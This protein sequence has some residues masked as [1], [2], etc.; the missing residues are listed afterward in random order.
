MLLNQFFDLEFTRPLT[1][2]EC[3]SKIPRYYQSNA[4]NKVADFVEEGYRRILINS[5]TGTGKTFIS[6]LVVLS[7]RVRQ[8]INLDSKSKIR[9]LYIANKHRLNRQA[10]KE[11]SQSTPA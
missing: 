3:I 4:V 6:K 5:P 8:I 11:Y 10:A 1:L 2:T 7:Q 9:V